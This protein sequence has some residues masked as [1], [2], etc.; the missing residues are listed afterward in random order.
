MEQ[1]NNPLVLAPMTGGMANR[2]SKFSLPTTHVH[3]AQNVLF[4]A[5]GSYSRMPGITQVISDA[6]AHSITEAGGG[7]FYAVGA[8][9]KFIDGNRVTHSVSSGLIP[10]APVAVADTP[11]GVYVSDG[12]NRVVVR[13]LIVAPWLPIEPVSA[14]ICATTTGGLPAGE[15]LVA[16][17]ISDA[18]GAESAPSPI[19]SVCLPSDGMG[20]AVSG[21]PNGS[22]SAGERLTVYVSTGAGAQLFAYSTPTAASELVSTFPV[23]QPLE[24]QYAQMLPPGQIL[25]HFNGRLFSAS[26]QFIAH[27]APYRLGEYNP[28]QDYVL[29]PADVTVV[30]DVADGLFVG[31][32]KLYFW[33]NAGT[34]NA[35]MRVVSDAKCVSGTAVAA[36]DDSVLVMS[37]RG[38]LR[39]GDNGRVEYLTDKTN[40]VTVRDVGSAGII[41]HLGEW[42]YACVFR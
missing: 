24:N 19:S 29:L 8:Q 42:Y 23:G 18:W 2:R 37:D 5:T 35:T 4:S 27:S 34:E 15:Y 22:L 3:D 28:A 32:D 16:Y 31:A 14:P 30:T 1:T 10:G 39:L 38:V 13:D 12:V 26:G 21:L 40:E 6:G 20:I 17:T 9:L 33:Q 41:H 11:A 25:I 7:W 36:P